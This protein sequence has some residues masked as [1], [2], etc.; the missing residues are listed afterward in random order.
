MVAFIEGYLVGLSLIILIGPV[1][2]VLLNTTLTHGR[3]SGLAVALGIF[4]SDVFIVF[5]CY[6]GSSEL[7]LTR[8]ST[9]WLTCCGTLVLMGMGIHYLK[10]PLME[11]DQQDPKIKSLLGFI[12]EG[13]AVNLINP[14]VFFIWFALIGVARHRYPNFLHQ[15]SY[16]T[17]ITLGIL[18]LDVSKALLAHHIRP[19]LNSQTL[20]KVQKLSGCLLLLFSLRL[21]GKL[22]FPLSF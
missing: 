2:F 14:F 17:A 7:S 6:S 19:L 3:M 8:T 12:G 1:L 5:L 10:A 21:L 11:I 4:L 18:T 15:V 16:L 22:I 9:W 13:I 20:K